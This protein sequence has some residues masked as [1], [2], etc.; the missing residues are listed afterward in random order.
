MTENRKRA[1]FDKIDTDGDGYITAMEL[2][3]SLG[4]E[5]NPNISDSNI[6]TIVKMADDNENRLIDFAEYEKLSR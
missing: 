3:I 6:D 5:R 2:K 4:A 1:E